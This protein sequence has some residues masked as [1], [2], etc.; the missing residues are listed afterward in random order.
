MKKIIDKSKIPLFYRSAS[1]SWRVKKTLRRPILNAMVSL[2][3]KV[4][5]LSAE[6]R[7]LPD[8]III[9]AQKCGTSTLYK[10]LL[11]H[12]NIVA[13]INI[14][15]PIKKEIHFVDIPQNYSKGTRWYK[16]HF[17]SNFY[18]NLYKKVLHREF[19]TGESSPGYLYFP[20]VSKRMKALLPNVK[21]IVMLRNPVDR[22]YSHYV[23][24]FR[25][26]KENLSFEEAVLKEEERIGE[27]FE[28]MRKNENFWDQ[29]VA[30]YGYKSRGIYAQVLDFLGLPKFMPKSYRKKTYP[31]YEKIKKD[32]RKK[33]VSYFKTHNE[34]L[35]DLIGE[36][37]DW[38][39]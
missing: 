9:G 1:L 21:I 7:V 39:R 27:G 26:L 6:N 36:R 28:M 24:I 29:N 23:H 30:R 3:L 10:A 33:L 25:P 15:A 22:A 37:F 11:Q 8:F 31:H 38:D 12:P 17:P 20:H 5:S 2:K 13:P 19:I 4:R 35:Y 16:T 14:I 32:T 18:R 34:R